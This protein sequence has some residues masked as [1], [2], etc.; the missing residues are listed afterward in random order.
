MAVVTGGGRGLGLA[1]TRELVARGCRVAICGRDGE[2]IDQAT[3][4]LRADGADVFGMSCDA[5]DPAQVSRF[6]AAVLGHYGRVDILINNAGQCFVGPAAELEVEDLRS[7]LQNIFWS[8]AHPTLAL[9]P[10][11]RGA[12]SGRIANITS[13]AGKVPLVHQAAYVAGKFAATGWS[14]AL[15]AELAKD[16]IHVSTIAPPP[17]RNGAPLHVHY[18]GRKEKEFR[19][20]A[21]CLSSPLTSTTAERTARVVVDAVE[22]GDR[23]RHVTVSCW[24]LSRLH[25]AFPTWMARALALVDRL[26]PPPAAAGQTERMQLGSV[27]VQ[28]TDDVCVRELAERVRKDEARYLPGRAIV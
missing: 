17:I 7:A 19:W 18:N 4:Q 14:E 1:I 23:E 27:L 20:F 28:S 15:S 16:G 5:S 25:G 26:M 24:L 8:Q 6:I 10:H 3:H 13:F 12:G 11:L 22:H 9:L 21:W 2:I